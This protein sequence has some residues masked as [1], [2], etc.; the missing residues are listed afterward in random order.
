MYD[1]NENK[2][3]FE[4]AGNY[5][6]LTIISC[7]L[8]G[9][10]TVLG[11]VPFICVYKVIEVFINNTENVSNSSNYALIALLFAVLSILIYYISL[12]F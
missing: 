10:S 11:V 7:I 9:I 3:V 1:D 12:S 4:F 6:Y 5:K 8:S 2:K